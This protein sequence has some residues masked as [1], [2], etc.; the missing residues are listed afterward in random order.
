MS[1][2]FYSLH[3]SFLVLSSIDKRKSV[4]KPVPGQK[5]YDE[6]IFNFKYLKNSELYETRIENSAELLDL[7]TEFREAHIDILKRFYLLFE[8]IY[9]YIQDFL[10]YIEDMEEGV[11]IQQTLEAT[12]PRHFF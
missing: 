9:K 10:K 1:C 8:S 3:I 6:I 4:S 5:R 2:F 12:L 7:D 11:F